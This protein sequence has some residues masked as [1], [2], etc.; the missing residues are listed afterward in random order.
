MTS[1]GQYGSEEE[2]VG[3]HFLRSGGVVE[4]GVPEGVQESDFDGGEV[5][6]LEV[7]GR[8]GV[9]CSEDLQRQC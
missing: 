2:G 7:D 9:F 4:D 5:R 8:D 3:S 6:V 1:G